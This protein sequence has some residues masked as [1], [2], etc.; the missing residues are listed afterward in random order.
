MMKDS[1]L[2][3]H[4]RLKSYEKRKKIIIKLFSDDGGLTYL[5]ICFFKGLVH[6]HFFSPDATNRHGIGMERERDQEIQVDIFA[7]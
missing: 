3:R 6:Q 2:D 1:S 4:K 5:P 7:D